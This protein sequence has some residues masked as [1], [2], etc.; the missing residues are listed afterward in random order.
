[1]THAVTETILVKISDVTPYD[2]NPRIN[3]HAVD[4][5]VI[6]IQ[7]YGFLVP[8]VLDKDGVIITGHTRYLAAKKL[9]M[10]EVPVIYATHLDE[11]QVS[12]FRIADNR[13]AQNATWDEDLLQE[14]LLSIQSMGFN[15]QFTGFS[16]EELDCLTDPISA[17]CLESLSYENV[18]GDTEETT[19]TKTAIVSVGV[20]TYKVSVTVEEFNTWEQ[21]MLTTFDNKASINLAILKRLGFKTDTTDA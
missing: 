15:L 12:A 4:P 3:E 18:C 1:M 9:K 7:Q 8:L 11:A 6:S 2:K 21:E 19:L 14:E 20:G 17:D 16:K 13:L 5:L 10:E